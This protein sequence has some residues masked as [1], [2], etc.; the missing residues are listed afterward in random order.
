MAYIS[1]LYGK[2]CSNSDVSQT[3]ANDRNWS[4]VINLSVGGEGSALTVHYYG[5]AENDLLPE[6]AGIYRLRKGAFEMISKDKKHLWNV[7]MGRHS[8]N[9]ISELEEVW[10]QF[11]DIEFNGGPLPA[12]YNGKVISS[13][14]QI[15][16]ARFAW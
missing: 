14:N 6:Q 5:S 1:F 9:A 3:R 4:R 12:N 2:H 13:K 15:H 16:Y 11:L 8:H 10:T 7:M